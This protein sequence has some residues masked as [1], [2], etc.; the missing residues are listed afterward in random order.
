MN[1][2]AARLLAILGPFLGLI[3]IYA[4]FALHDLAA[5]GSIDQLGTLFSRYNLKTV[6]AQTSI[7]A[8]AALGMTLVI[9]S[10]GIDLSAGSSIAL[11]TV[12]VAVT[13][14]GL[15]ASD[16]PGDTAGAL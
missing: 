9:I 6:A 2:Q 1:R 3:L 15:S 5:D 11:T 12:V 14:R 13:L 16:P 7:V 10:G 8:I 4:F